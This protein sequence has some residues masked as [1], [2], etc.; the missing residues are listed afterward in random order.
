[1]PPVRPQDCSE[2][3]SSLYSL[4]GKAA[5]LR[6]RPSPSCCRAPFS[7]PKPLTAAQSRPGRGG[8]ISGAAAT[9]SGCHVG[10]MCWRRQNS[11]NA[12]TPNANTCIGSPDDQV[13]IARAALKEKRRRTEA[14]AI[15]GAC[16][17]IGFRAAP[18]SA[19]AIS[20][21]E[22][23]DSRTGRQR[24][25]QGTLALAR[26][27]GS[28]ARLPGAIL[29]GSAKNLEQPSKGLIE[30]HLG[31]LLWSRWSRPALSQEAAF[32]RELRGLQTTAAQERSEPR[33][34]RKGAL[35]LPS[36]AAPEVVA[37]PSG[38]PG[39]LLLLRAPLT[40]R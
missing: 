19:V 18:V 5:R 10:R 27:A 21:Y 24:D 8:C 20:C 12:C 35:A 22:S 6:P 30:N 38:L 9:R 3:S 29:T 32:R 14:P 33:W 1:M 4:S 17:Q 23:G 36:R 16:V 26:C 37:T 31:S 7:A 25:C 2:S 39:P 34:I 40:A 28:L 13:T 11:C 15:A